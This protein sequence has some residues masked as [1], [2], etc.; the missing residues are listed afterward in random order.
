MMP[1]DYSTLSMHDMRTMPLIA[2][3]GEEN[4]EDQA[5]QEKVG[6][7]EI[8]IFG[9]KITYAKAFGIAFL[10]LFVLL[11]FPGIGVS[12]SVVKKDT[13]EE[14]DETEKDPE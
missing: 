12:S 6:P 11:F 3:E 2:Q 13:N 10:V 8:S 4:E 7:K 5:G 14:N 1:K 9:I